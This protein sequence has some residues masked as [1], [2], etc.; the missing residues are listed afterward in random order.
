MKLKL[1]KNLMIIC[2]SFGLA[3]TS[4]PASVLAAG[5]TTVETYSE[6]VTE[7][8][9]SS[10]ETEKETK[11]QS[12][13]EVRSGF[14][15]EIEAVQT[16]AQVQEI[17]PE[18][19]G[20]TGKVVRSGGRNPITVGEE[21]KDYEIDE[22]GKYII[23][24]DCTMTLKD[25]DSL[26]DITVN[27]GATLS[28]YMKG[29]K[30]NSITNI[31]GTGKVVFCKTKTVVNEGNQV[32]MV[33]NGK[34]SLKGNISVAE[35]TME[36]GTLFGTGIVQS[37]KVVVK[38]GS[39]ACNVSESSEIRNSS[40]KELKKITVSVEKNSACV[41]GDDKDNIVWSDK[42]GKL[43]LYFATNT[44]VAF[45][46]DAITFSVSED[47]S[48]ITAKKQAYIYE[49]SELKKGQSATLYMVKAGAILETVYGEKM[50]NVDIISV[51][52]ANSGYL[53]KVDL[54][55]FDETKLELKAR[56]SET[57][58]YKVTKSEIKAEPGEYTYDLST[59]TVTDVFEFEH[60]LSGTVTLKIE[61]KELTPTIT[62]NKAS[63]TSK[64]KATKVYDG[65]T[66]VPEDTCELTGF[67]NVVDGDKAA[68][69]LAVATA[70][71]VYDHA[72]VATAKKITAT[73]TL[74]GDWAK[75]YT[76]ASVEKSAEITK[77]PCPE[78]L[79]KKLVKPTLEE[80]HYEWFSYK[81][82]AGQE[83]AYSEKAKD[84]EWKLSKNA[85]TITYINEV[86]GEE[87]ALKAGTSYK[88][89][90]RIPESDN[91]LASDPVS[92]SFKT[93]RAPKEAKE[94]DVKLTGVTDNSTQKLDTALE[95]TATG[96]TYVDEKDY[97]PS[98]DD[99]KY[100]PY[101]WK[102]T[103]T[104]TWKNQ[105]STQKFTVKPTKAGTYTIVATFRKYV[106]NGE[107]WER[108]EDGDV[109]KSITFK[110]NSTGT[111]TSGSSGSSS[112]STVKSSTTAAKTGDTTPLIPVAAAF[113]LSG[114]AIAAVMKKRK[115]VQ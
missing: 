12:E 88:V 112:G 101:S 7:V 61:K 24:K 67:T 19:E 4:V 3:V 87:V 64:N 68:D 5:D 76:V 48:S 71:Y 15:P 103:E 1:L 46:T 17:V 36:G 43:V 50:E 53:S 97:E 82:T 30:E 44:P 60:K 42:D 92:V 55:G 104:T 22:N 73:V 94:S 86:D 80:R 113:V 33:S 23:N 49:D 81:T 106:Y 26:G 54:P 102:L 41:L 37:P 18:T 51:T 14:I 58:G 99:E 100:V 56:T 75:K 31:D 66:D 45:Q 47:G 11:H 13:T 70:S 79:T 91:Y 78:E 20:A 65:T 8:H 115:K 16:E 40:E 2:M 62:I 105:K 111:S 35:L 110:A 93:L 83:Y 21:G 34:V 96:S 74:K 72:D 25:G 39:L 28:I 32:K 63:T 9:Q 89:Y 52:G 109:K 77:A 38:G 108:D 10:T 84:D 29:T 98:L 69:I 95:F 27:S 90:T 59:V 114:A 85:E 107:E 57:Q 6:E